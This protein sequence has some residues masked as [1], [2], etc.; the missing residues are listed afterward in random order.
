MLFAI[1]LG[2]AIGS[3]A[4]YLVVSQMTRWLGA[5]FPWGTLTVNVIGGFVVG[6][7][8][9]AMV[10]KWSVGPELRAFLIVGVLGGFTTFSAFSLDVVSLTQNGAVGTAFVYA[11]ASVMLSVAAAFVGLMF[12]RWMLG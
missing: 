2:G 3:V 7:L 9:E 11:F 10:L 4:R 6:L 5:A 8:A 12:T 1:A